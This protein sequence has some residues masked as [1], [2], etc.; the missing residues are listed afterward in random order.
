MQCIFYRQ[1]TMKKKIRG[2]IARWV[3]ANCL[4]LKILS[5]AGAQELLPPLD[6][7]MLLSGNFGELRAT[8]FHSGVD[9]KT[10]GVEGLPVRCVQ[11]GI[12]SRVCVSPTGYGN[13]LYIDHPDGT[14]TVYAHL[15]RFEPRVATRVREKQYTRESFRVD[16]PMLAENIRFRRGDTIGYSGNTGSSGGP[17]LHFEVRTTSTEHTLNPLRFYSIRDTRA[18]IPKHLYL[19]AVQDNGSVQR[20]RSCALKNTGTGRYSAGRHTVPAGKIGIGAFIID[21]MNDSWNKLGVYRLTLTVGQD[22]LY[23]LS[24]D[25]CA[26]HQACFINEVKDFECY[27]KR[28]TVYRCFG[29]WQHEVLGVR[30][31]NGGCIPLSQDSTVHALLTLADING[32]RSTVALELRGA[33]PAPDTL[34]DGEILRYDLPHQL[35]HGPWSLRLPAGS[36]ISSVRKTL[37]SEPDTATGSEIL[38]LARKDIPLLKKGTLVLRGRFS[39]RSVICEVTPEGERLPVATRHTS[40]SLCASIG[41]LNRYTVAEDTLAPT[42]DYLGKGP[43]RTLRF[44]I[45]DDCSGIAS[46]R[47][48]V[49]GQWC[50]FSYDPRTDLLQCLLSEPAFRRGARNEVRIIVED[51][52]NNQTEITKHI[53]L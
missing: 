13:A 42:I 43:G 7:T 31:R 6:G 9:M 14:T 33:A 18:P 8:H 32:N 50:L 51:K 47:G 44:R 22:T 34:P 48:E 35:T 17:H 36:L 19:Y 2:S 45:K 38:M 10:G 28:E 21:H 37:A 41:Y 12:V 29:H 26:F 5:P 49:N 30:M 53:T 15:Q 39:P 11:D 24:A 1:E 16:E 23:H 27:K 20:L 52:V 3:A 4:M 46:Y 40:D 25:S